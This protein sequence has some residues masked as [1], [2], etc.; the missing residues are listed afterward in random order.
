VSDNVFLLG[1]GNITV[2]APNGGEVWNINTTKAIQWN[3]SGITGNVKIELSRDGG[4]TWEV[5]FASTAN[6]GTQNWRAT[7]PATS[8]ARIRVSGVNDPTVF[9]SSDAPFRVQ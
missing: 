4:T 3:A 6:D 9:D 2:L 7:A 1:G 8:E 5:L